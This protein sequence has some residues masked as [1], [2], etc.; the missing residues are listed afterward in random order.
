MR[1]KFGRDPMAGSKKVTFK[2][3]SQQLMCNGPEY[4]VMSLVVLDSTSHSLNAV[5][6]TMPFHSCSTL[7]TLF[8]FIRQVSYIQWC[9][10]G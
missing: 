3:R 2:F 4:I 10:Y 9:R 5:T 8:T 1:A 6:V 7:S